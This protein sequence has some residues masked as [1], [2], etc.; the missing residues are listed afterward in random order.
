MESTDRLPQMV[1]PN[2]LSRNSS[3]L[4]NFSAMVEM[5]GVAIIMITQEIR[6]PQQEANTPPKRALPP[7]PCTR[8]R[9]SS[10]SRLA[11]LRP[12]SSLTRRPQ[13]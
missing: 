5:K 13:P 6:V 10:N 3:H 4:P 9:P 1:M 12:V 8:I 7:L 2:T 11:K